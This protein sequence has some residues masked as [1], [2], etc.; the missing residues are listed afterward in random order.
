MRDR[1]EKRSSVL[2]LSLFV[3]RDGKICHFL[4]AKRPVKKR[5]RETRERR[6]KRDNAIRSEK[7]GGRNRSWIVSS[8]TRSVDRSTD[9]PTAKPIRF[10]QLRAIGIR[11]VI[12]RYGHSPTC[13]STALKINSLVCH[14]YVATRSIHRYIDG[15]IGRVQLYLSREKLKVTRFENV[16]MEF[17]FPLVR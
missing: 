13:S 15:K 7:R 11:D 6:N 2:A 8:L 12:Y 1:F 5:E 4:N 14:R 9:R 3:L 10:D 17:F 16:W